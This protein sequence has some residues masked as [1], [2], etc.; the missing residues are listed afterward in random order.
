MKVWNARSR[1]PSWP[2]GWQR[3]PIIYP[4]LH[5]PLLNNNFAAKYAVAGHYLTI[6]VD[7]EAISTPTLQPKLWCWTGK[8]TPSSQPQQRTLQIWQLLITSA[9]TPVVRRW[10]PL[11]AGSR[12][13]ECWLFFDGHRRMSDFTGTSQR[14]GGNGGKKMKKR[15]VMGSTASTANKRKCVQSL[16]ICL[17]FLSW[18]EFFFF[19]PAPAKTGL[20]PTTQA[21]SVCDLI[22]TERLGNHIWLTDSQTGLLPKRGKW[23]WSWWETERENR[24]RGGER[25]LMSELK[26]TRWSDP[27]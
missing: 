2:L 4:S 7:K 1:K 10:T 19:F 21:L 9:C 13:A 14:E 23:P 8:R 16:F 3:A 11:T 27:L 26:R 5:F 6:P 25:E 22:M 15:H 12:V 20:A 17:R 18:A 24:P